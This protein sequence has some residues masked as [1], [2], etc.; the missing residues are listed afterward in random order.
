MP[1]FHLPA[2]TLLCLLA[3]QAD[4][5][6]QNS[7]L[8]R[9]AAARRHTLMQVRARPALRAI[10]AFVQP[11]QFHPRTRQYTSPGDTPSPKVTYGANESTGPTYPHPSATRQQASV[12]D[13]NASHFSENVAAAYEAA[14]ASSVKSFE[15]VK[16]KPMHRNMFT[17]TGNLG[18][19]PEIVTLNGTTL[20]KMRLGFTQANSKT[21]WCATFCLH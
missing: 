3:T 21:G 7:L 17:I 19:D 15:K 1:L 6:N 18:A 9:T 11:Q 20:A 2:I 8:G 5:R 16:Y 13:G 12:E 14:G 10:T 4:K